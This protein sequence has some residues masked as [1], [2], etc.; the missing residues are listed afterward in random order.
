M[1]QPHI[2][3][4]ARAARFLKQHPFEWIGLARSVWSS[5]KFR[6]LLRCAGRGTIVGH[7][8]QIINFSNVRIG[9]GCLIQDNVYMRAGTGGSIVLADGV[10]INSFAKLFGH[11]GIEVGAHS[12][13]G[14]GA[15][16][17]TTTH[18]AQDRMETFF[19]PISI[20]E[21]AWIGANVTVLS[22]VRIGNRCVV[23][24]GSLVNRDL[25]DDSIAVG[26][27]ARVI[28]RTSST[29][30]DGAPP[31]AG[32]SA[33]AAEPDGINGRSVE[34]GRAHV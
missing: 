20:G 16:L 2:D 18:D 4:R 14:P 5:V 22:G 28:K 1:A 29:A 6:Y 7:D 3:V 15:V 13:I 8:T 32:R 27:P 26:V 11:G 31:E 30:L 19:E 21:W 24:A 12:Q 10:A 33:T 25:P 9:S 23:G 34:I 17:T